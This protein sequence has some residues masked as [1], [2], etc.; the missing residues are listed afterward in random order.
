M[1]DGHLIL[2]LQRKRPDPN[3]RVHWTN[4]TVDNE[5]LGRKKSKKCCIFHKKRE[6]DE[7]DSESSEDIDQIDRD[8]AP[9]R[10]KWAEGTV[11]NE[12]LG[13]KKSKKCCIFHK[14]RQWDESDSESSE[15]SDDSREKLRPD[16]SASS[17]PSKEE[18]I[19]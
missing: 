16:K 8:P 17:K 12:F 3:H 2:K 4:D 9:R 10:V 11:D 15:D 5:G 1:G 14:K 7:S 19:S 18:R 6:W 13:R